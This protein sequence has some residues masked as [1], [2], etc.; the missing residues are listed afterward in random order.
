LAF[1]RLVEAGCVS[2]YPQLVEKNGAAVAQAEHTVAVLPEK[3][4]VLTR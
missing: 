1:K 4:I 2:K 3:T